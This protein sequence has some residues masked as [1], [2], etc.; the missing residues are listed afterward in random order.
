MKMQRIPFYAMVMGLIIAGLI[1]AWLRHTT[2]EVPFLPGEQKPVWLIE[3]RI[4]FVATGGQTTV[5]LDL[6]DAPP[7]FRL[8]REQAA[9]PG[10]GFAVLDDNQNRRAEWTRRQV[11]GPQTLYYNAQYLPVSQNSSAIEAEPP[12]VAEVFWDE[13]EATAAR[14]LLRGALSRSTTPASTARELI[15]LLSPNSPDQNAQLL[16]VA[17]PQ[18]S[19]LLVKLL[20]QAG[21][22]ARTALGLYLEDAR[23]RQN[24]TSMVEL[25]TEEGWLLINAT[26]GEQG[27]PENLLLWSRGEYS[28]LDVIGGQNSRLS[29]SMIKQTVPAM[30]L[31]QVQFQDNIFSMLGV[32]SLPIEEQ[33][34]FKLL[35]LLPLG[36]LV[37]VFMRVMVGLRTAGTFMP[38]LI[39]LAFLQTSLIPGLI[40]FVLIVGFGLL[41]RNY[42]S[43][44]NLLLVA[45]IATL[46]VLVIFLISILSLVGYQMGLNAGITVTFF[47]MIIIA[48]TIERMSI[49]WEEEGAHEVLIQGGGSLLVAVI[50]YLLMSLTV[51]NHLSF[52]F[53]ELNLIILALILMMGQ[54]TGYKLSE[55]RRFRSMEQFD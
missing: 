22:A 17:E 41:L 42:L 4:D 2:T 36:A 37:V 21:V 55:L 19:Q 49:L 46:I 54:Y 6:P 15:K 24:L 47:P 23:R 35:F 5:R 1:T 48:W 7:G 16:L 30:A 32:Y 43:Y 33:S 8:I 38:I 50:A 53:P 27:V 34:M 39:S 44:L 25:Y 3:A 10:Y 51:V 31:S 11:A 20:N 12:Q 26:T 14:E 29:F 18:R 28:Q 9:S 52:N 13:P 45:R 40:S